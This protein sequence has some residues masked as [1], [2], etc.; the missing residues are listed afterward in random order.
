MTAVEKNLTCTDNKSLNKSNADS[1]RLFIETGAE[2]LRKG[3]HVKFRAPGDSMY[4]TICNGDFITVMPVEIDSI[5]IED[6]ILYRHTSGVAAH[7]VIRIEK[8]DAHHCAGSAPLSQS[9]VLSLSRRS[10]TRAKA[11]PQ[12]LFIL[13]GDAAIER[14][15]PVRSE[16][17]LGK[18]ISIER[19]GHR[20]DPYC[21]RIKLL[22]KT[23]RFVSRMKR[24]LSRSN[25][26][27]I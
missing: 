4:P 6:I 19:N 23:R 12:H 7:R 21:L 15:A 3:H 20:I 14:D 13:R 2:L 27:Y 18:V 16:Q 8:R 17:I 10:S 26:K 11:V 22:F 5:V 25:P 1:D 9:S 24:L